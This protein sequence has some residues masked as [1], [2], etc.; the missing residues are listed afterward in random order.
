MFVAL[1]VL[2]FSFQQ[3]GRIGWQDVGNYLVAGSPA[4]LVPLI[5]GLFLRWRWLRKKNAAQ[6]FEHR[7]KG[8]APLDF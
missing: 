7:L 3:R 8:L 4:Y 6:A 5:V 1:A 2:L